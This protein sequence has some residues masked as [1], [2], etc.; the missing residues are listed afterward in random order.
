MWQILLELGHELYASASDSCP[1][2]Q[3]LLVVTVI[4]R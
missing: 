4:R 2:G 3:P 1:A